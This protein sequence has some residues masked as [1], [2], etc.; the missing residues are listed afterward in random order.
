MLEASVPISMLEA[1]VPI[2][3]SEGVRT[4]GSMRTHEHAYLQ[5][6]ILGYEVHQ[7][8]NVIPKTWAANPVWLEQ[9][10][11]PTGVVGLLQEEVRN[12]GMREAGNLW[13]G[14]QHQDRIE[15]FLRG[16]RLGIRKLPGRP[17]RSLVPR[18][19]RHS[20]YDKI[21][22]HQVKT[23]V[24]IAYVEQRQ[25]AWPFAQVVNQVIDAVVLRRLAGLR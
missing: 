12:S 22:R 15:H 5:G 10:A 14:R 11:R 6:R 18:Q 2:S 17:N 4:A 8:L 9:L 23:Y 1:C 21:K 16:Q 7:L 24:P 20:F 19:H 25:P 13:G 3:T